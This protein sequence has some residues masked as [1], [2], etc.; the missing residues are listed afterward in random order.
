M[1]DPIGTSQAR[2][3]RIPKIAIR[4]AALFFVLSVLLILIVIIF[5][6]RTLSAGLATVAHQ[7]ETDALI[8]RIRGTAAVQLASGLFIISSLGGVAIWV[9]VG[10][11]LRKLTAAATGLGEGDLTRRIDLD[12]T[13]D[14]IRDLSVGFNR[15]AAQLQIAF[16]TEKEQIQRLSYT[17]ASLRKSEERFRALINNSIDIVSVLDPDGSVI[18]QSPSMTDVLGYRVEDTQEANVFEFVHPEDVESMRAAVDRASK[19]LTPQPVEARLKARDATWRDLE[20]YCVGVW[21]EGEFYGILANGRDITQW[22]KLQ[23][24]LVQSQKMEALGRLAGGVAHDFNNLLTVIGAYAELLDLDETDEER[25]VWFAEIAQAAQRATS[26]TGQLLAFSRRQVLKPESVDVNKAIRDLQNLLARLIGEETEIRVE[27][28]KDVG[29]VLVDPTQIDQIVFNL[30]INAKD[31]MDGAGTMIIRTKAGR[32]DNSDPDSAEAVFLE[33]VDTGHGMDQQTK[34]QIFDPFFTTK[35]PGKGTGL[36]LATVHGIVTQSGGSI[37]VESEP[38]EGTVF[39]VVL[40]VFAG[41][42]PAPRSG[43]IV[44]EV[45]SSRTASRVL[46]VEDEPAVLNLI[47]ISLD[48]IGHD[49][50]TAGNATEALAAI[51]EVGNVDL[52]ITD[53]ILPGEMNGAELADE[54]AALSPTTAIIHISGYSGE[55]HDSPIFQREDRTLLAKP[56]DRK[57]LVEAVHEVLNE[58]E[59][60]G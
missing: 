30:A 8:E 25:K 18:F 19:G 48:R 3:T 26:L 31:A 28:S 43:P 33:I 56:F 60:G 58:A 37:L 15:M 46:V 17:Q 34:D 35:E 27:L 50:L 45:V 40:P 7:I 38:G 54:V 16:D 42:V 11:P 4:L 22:K 53:L 5:V 59:S 9:I 14:E 36:G 29:P 6:D 57:D 51:N 55:T 20:I 21:I 12:E 32:L 23:S 49:V 39:T 2:S 13:V 24:Q 10:K 47:K 1:S 44:T 41:E 52:L